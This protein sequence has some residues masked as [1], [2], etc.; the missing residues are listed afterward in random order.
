M[1]GDIAHPPVS[2]MFPPSE[3]IFDSHKL[4]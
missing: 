1:F 3:V 4:N 2:N